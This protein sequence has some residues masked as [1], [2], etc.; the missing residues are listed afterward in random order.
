MIDEKKVKGVIVYLERRKTRTYVGVLY[1]E[2]KEFVFEYDK[3]YL[4]ANNVI[5]VGLELPLTQS[6]FRSKHIFPSFQD[7]LP[8]RENPAYKEYCEAE[9]ISVDEVDPFVLL[10]T[11]GKKGPS[12]FVFEPLFQFRTFNGQNIRTYREWL[13]LTTREFADCFEISRSTLLR[14]ENEKETGAEALKRLEI[15]VKY[16]H[17]AFDQVKNRGGKMINK[18]RRSVESKLQKEI[19]KKATPHS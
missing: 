6:T 1:E 18:K 8:S 3:K 2:N 7:R 11:I 13:G 14:I 16:P 19:A 15:F 17:V 9:G 5:P 10:A 4:Y 12:S